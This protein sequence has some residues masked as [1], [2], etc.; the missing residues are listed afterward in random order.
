MADHEAAQPLLR[1]KRSGTGQS[2]VG[3]YTRAGIFAGNDSVVGP[4]TPP[5]QACSGCPRAPRKTAKNRRRRGGER[6]LTVVARA[7][8]CA[9]TAAQ[10]SGLELWRGLGRLYLVVVMTD[11]WAALPAAAAV[12]QAQHHSQAPVWERDPT[13]SAAPA[14]TANSCAAHGTASTYS[15]HHRLREGMTRGAQPAGLSV[16]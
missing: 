1:E 2:G 4:R 12:A 15:H 7:L 5:P 3:M 16:G 11:E 14:R 6:R 8:R 10:H 13:G 9:A